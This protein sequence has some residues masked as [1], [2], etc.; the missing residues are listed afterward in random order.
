MSNFWNWYTTKPAVVRYDYKAGDRSGQTRIGTIVRVNNEK[1]TCDVEYTYGEQGII[2][3]VPLGLPFVT[4]RGFLGG[5]PEVGSQVVLTMISVSATEETPIIVSFLP[6][7]FPVT[8]Y[9]NDKVFAQSSQIP[10]YR[11]TKTSTRLKNQRLYPG[12]IFISSDKGSDIRVD[13]DIVLTNRKLSEIQLRSSDQSIVMNSLQF[14]HASDAKTKFEGMV[15]RYMETLFDHEGNLLDKNSLVHDNFGLS[16]ESDKKKR[17]SYRSGFVDTSA[18]LVTPDLDQNFIMMD[19]GNYNWVRTLSGK[20]TIDDPYLVSY[21]DTIDP[22]VKKNLQREIAY[23]SLPLTESRYAI[24]ELGDA[25]LDQSYPFLDNDL[26]LREDNKAKP[27]SGVPD[28]VF[29]SKNLIESVQ[30]TLVG[31]DFINKPELYG[32]VLRH[33]LFPS[34]DTTQVSSEEIA[35]EGESLPDFAKTRTWSVASMWKMPSYTSQTRFYVNKEGFISFHVGSTRSKREHLFLESSG[36]KV[37][38][39]SENPI[40]AGRSVE[41]SFGGSIRLLVEKDYKEESLELTAL[42]RSFINLG[43]DDR[44]DYGYRAPTMLDGYEAPVGVFESEDLKNSISE[45]ISLDLTTDGGLVM[46]LGKNNESLVR[47]FRHNGYDPKGSTLNREIYQSSKNLNKKDGFYSIGDAPY[48]FHDMQFPSIIDGYHNASTKPVISNPNRMASSLDAHLCG[49]AMIRIGAD[50]TDNKSLVLDL[51]GALVAAIGKD[52]H[53]GRSIQAML[54]GGIEVD[55][56]KITKTGHSIQGILR[57]DVDLRI[58]SSNPM[59]EEG[60]VSPKHHHQKSGPGLTTEGNKARLHKGSLRSSIEGNVLMNIDGRQELKLG[61]NRYESINGSS[62]AFILAHHKVTIGNSNFLLGNT[63]AYEVSAAQGSMKLATTIGDLRFETK[64]GNVIIDTFLGNMDYR[65]TA[66]NIVVNTLKGDFEGSSV[67]GN[68]SMKTAK[69]NATVSTLVGDVELS[70]KQGDITL[71][72]KIG[73]ATMKSEIMA[74][75]MA[76]LVQIEAKIMKVNAELMLLGGSK[77]THPIPK[78]DMLQ[79]WLMTH[80][81]GTPGTPPVTP[82]NP[83]ILS[84]TTLTS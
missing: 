75:I 36:T 80:V 65:T 21:P 5:M 56:G 15:T 8:A 41:G 38:P 3:D 76:K 29:F 33:Q 25:I 6:P 39:V 12:E 77:A 27:L 79:A 82:F 50:S 84:T 17:L 22:T 48:R 59:D 72:T 60:A 26:D 40:G 10:G 35:I 7:Y 14:Y 13:E 83:A 53:D 74:E 55:I 28:K 49:D 67:I 31:Y 23:S 47:K 42:G 64:K 34:A 30:G 44:L 78:G 20:L 70:T 54:D 19:D 43:C 81:H 1:M 52:S 73:T 4:Q 9:N 46:R 61:G 18:S 37:M 51:A 62:E 57:G 58:L 2:P 69:G 66:G 11:S 71:S 32:K 63:T 68:V 24:K 45:R 16:P